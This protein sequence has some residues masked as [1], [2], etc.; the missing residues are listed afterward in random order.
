MV[1]RIL[2]SAS[3]IGLIY[4]SY[5]IGVELYN[6]MY[7]QIKEEVKLELKEEN[8]YKYDYEFI[9]P[10]QPV[11]EYYLAMEGIRI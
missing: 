3:I 11:D 1:K 2:I 9:E 4:A 10:V 8:S 7:E 6:Y 5:N